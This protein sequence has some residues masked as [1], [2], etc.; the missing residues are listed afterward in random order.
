MGKK[1]K[2]ARIGN[3]VVRAAAEAA[4]RKRIADAQAIRH[5]ELNGDDLL[6][7]DDLDEAENLMDAFMTEYP[8]WSI[9]GGREQPWE[10]TSQIIRAFDGFVL[11]RNEAAENMDV[12]DLNQC[13][14]I[15]N[16]TDIAPDVREFLVKHGL[17][18]AG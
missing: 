14:K 13:F 12:L 15:N 2:G 3:P 4:E 16:V 1:K 6:D 5:S 7:N 10:V 18:G 11:W 8:Q 9:E 17:I